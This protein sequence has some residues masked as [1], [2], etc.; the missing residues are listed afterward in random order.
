LGERRDVLQGTSQDGARLLLKTPQL[1]GRIENVK[2]VPLQHLKS[3]IQIHRTLRKAAYLHVHPEA[4]T[5][6]ARLGVEEISSRILEFDI[7]IIV[8][9]VRVSVG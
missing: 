6:I 3:L 9:C 5:I 2:Y 1:A 7:L 8:W 4:I